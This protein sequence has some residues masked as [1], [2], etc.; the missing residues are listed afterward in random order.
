MKYIK[1]EHGSGGALS[2]QLTEEIIYPI[3]K[4]NIYTELSDAAVIE[5]NGKIAFTTDTYVVDP[6]FFPGGDIG[7]LA[8]CGTCN[9]LSVSG[10]KPQY[11]SLG[12]IIEEGFPIE[13]LIR[14]LNSIRSTADSAGVNIITG[15]TKVVPSGKGGN[16]YINTSGIGIKEYSEIISASRI[17]VNDAVIISGPIGSHGIAIMASRESINIGSKIRSDVALLYPLCRSLFDLGSRLRFLRDT[18]RGGLAAILNE[19]C[20]GNN[21]GLNIRESTIPVNEDV[22]AV[23]DI[24]G[25]NPIEIAN[26]GVLTLVTDPGSAQE[27]LDILHR[28]ETGKEA[29]VIGNVTEAYPGRVILETLVGGKRIL[30]YPRGLLLPRIC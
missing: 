18:T 22:R 28:H 29:A 11:L 1:L 17:G 14:I 2:R 16:I 26:E 10:S 23:S 30:D 13:Q 20:S 27:V 19:I 9:D 7:K 12:L 15:D 5:A 6:V 8:V 24:L 25:L 4:N 3:L 21:F